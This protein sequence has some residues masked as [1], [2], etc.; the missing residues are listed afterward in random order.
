MQRGLKTLVNTLIAEVKLLLYLLFVHSA[1]RPLFAS[2]KQ[3]AE[4][5]VRSLHASS[6]RF[7]YTLVNHTS[8]IVTAM[9]C[10]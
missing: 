7:F 4:F 1:L 9:G 2:W 10:G 8:P 6:K 3:G 5:D